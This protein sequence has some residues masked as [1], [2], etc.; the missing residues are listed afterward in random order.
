MILLIE[1][2]KKTETGYF[3]HFRDKTGIIHGTLNKYVCFLSKCVNPSE[4]IKQH[5]HGIECGS[6]IVADCIP[7]LSITQSNSKY[8]VLT[9]RCVCQVITKFSKDC[10][11]FCKHLFQ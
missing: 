1:K 4:I 10:F 5:R 2:V 3:C 6:I 11:V 9:K 8:L 7:I